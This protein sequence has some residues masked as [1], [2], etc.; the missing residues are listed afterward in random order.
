M[1]NSV[2]QIKDFL[3][4]VSGLFPV[5]LSEKQNLD[6]YA[7]KLYEK[8]TILTAMQNDEIISLVAGYTENIV[9]NMAFIAIVATLPEMQGKGLAAKL[10]KEFIG[11]C[12][13]KG[14]DSVHLYAV[15]DNFPAV[16]M[17]K[18]LGFTEDF[19]ETEPRPRDLHL[20]YKIKE[21]V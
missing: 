6:D 12:N 20:I 10:V 11:L 8:A 14:I 13:K 17:Y 1:K 2:S 7:V 21:G 18:S 4:K 16:K 19:P 15:R 5:P 3:F 9:D